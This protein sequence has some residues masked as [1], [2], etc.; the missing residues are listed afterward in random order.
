MDKSKL[1]SMI[2]QKLLSIIMQKLAFLILKKSC[3]SGDET[4]VFIRHNNKKREN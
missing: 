1:L 2:M 4:D 3:K